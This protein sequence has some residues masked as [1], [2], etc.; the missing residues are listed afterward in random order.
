MHRLNAPFGAGSQLA[1]LSVPG[2]WFWK[3]EVERP[4]RVGPE[5]HVTADRET[6]E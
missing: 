3:V 4:I 1:S 6:I 5:R 2:L